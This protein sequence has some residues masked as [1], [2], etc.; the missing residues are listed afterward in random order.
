MMLSQTIDTTVRG[1]AY[2]AAGSVGDELLG[3]GAGL[4][5]E[6]AQRSSIPYAL[7]DAD[8]ATRG[9]WLRA[10]A[11]A[12]DRLLGGEPLGSPLQAGLR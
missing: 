2:E 10:A 6:A 5:R 7:L 12:V 3:R 11:A 4:V 9:E 8:P 1:I